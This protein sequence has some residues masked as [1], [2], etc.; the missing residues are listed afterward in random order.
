MTY[1]TEK[2]MKIIDFLSTNKKNSYSIEE[3]CRGVLPDGHG[4]ST[5]YRQVSAL[6]NDGFVRR[7]ATDK[8]RE[9]IDKQ[10][11]NSAFKTLTTLQ[12]ERILKTTL[13]STETAPPLSSAMRSRCIA[14]N[15]FLLIHSFRTPPSE[16]RRNIGLLA[17]AA[18]AP[19]NKDEVMTEWTQRI[20]FLN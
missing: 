6:V 18:G 9:F 7:M 19:Y 4:K 14:G 10:L 17:N 1:N 2:R 20:L 11:L 16:R 12:R 13:K 15:N 3:I 8:G 5:V